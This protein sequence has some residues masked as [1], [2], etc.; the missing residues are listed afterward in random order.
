MLKKIIKGFIVTGCI[1]LLPAIWQRSFLFFPQP[2]ILLLVG[3]V[4]AIYQPDYNPF[5]KKPK[6]ADKGTALS[7]IWA[8]YLL[9]LL[10]IIEAVYFNFPESVKW[11]IVAT[12]SVVLMVFGVIIRAWSCV[13]LGNLFSM[14][15][16]VQEDHRIVWAGPYKYIRHPSYIGAF[17]VSVFA[18]SFLHSWLAMALSLVVLPAVYYRRMYYEELFLIKVFGQE[19][20]DYCARVKRVIPGLW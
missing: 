12:V 18:N 11:D 13:T 16:A 9:Q 6:K 14:H 15:I 4:V 3:I 5:D 17:L 8:I 10:A 20:Q 2:W 7:V 1:V 19:Y